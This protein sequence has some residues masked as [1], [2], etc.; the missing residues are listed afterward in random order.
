MKI[1]L[2]CEYSGRV[3]EAFAKLGHNVMSC[4]LLPTEQPGNH[5]QGNIFD[6]LNDG[7]DMLIAHPP[8]TYLTNA[9]SWCYYHP[10]D[11]HLEPDKRRPHPKF[12]NRR[13][14]RWDAIAFF[15]S[16]QAAPIPKICIENPVPMGVVIAHIGPYT[17]TIQPYM[18]GEDASKRTCLWLKGLPP[19]KVTNLIKK[20]IYGNQT[21]S[22]QNRLGPSPDR[23]KERS[24]TYQGIADAMAAQ[25]GGANCELLLF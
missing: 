25:W 4:D 23:W 22:G 17:Q 5:Y 10:A 7:W 13:Q 9:Q 15:K 6:V 11:K 16:L 1:L 21:P 18:F 2:G 24:R 12:P 20:K 14:Q 3:R 8:C 19:L